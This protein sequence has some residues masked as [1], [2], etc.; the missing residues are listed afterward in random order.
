[1]INSRKIKDSLVYLVITLKKKWK[2]LMNWSSSSFLSSK[3]SPPHP[4]LALQHIT[5]CSLPSSTSSVWSHRFP[6]ICLPPVIVLYQIPT[7]QSFPGNYETTL[8]RETGR[9]TTN[10]H[11]SLLSSKSNSTVSSPALQQTAYC[12]LSSLSVFFNK[13]LSRYWWNILPF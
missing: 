2:H 8:V 7:Q 10:L 12:G 5:C 6:P 4:F 1:M 11:L 9:L 3:S 13:G